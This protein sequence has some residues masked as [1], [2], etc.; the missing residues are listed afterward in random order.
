MARKHVI[1][2]HPLIW[3]LEGNV[4]LAARAR[5]VLD[6]PRSDLVLPVIALAE[7]T[8]LV[9]RRRVRISSVPSLLADI[10]ADP[11]IAIAPL[12]WDVFQHS[13]SLQAIPEMHDRFNVAT[14]LHLQSQGHTVTL[15]TKDET[16]TT[17]EF[18]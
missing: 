18:R 4:R 17:Y 5:A 15:V 3:Y 8:F 12:T 2:T 10:Q 6:D 9:E 16:I 14:A 11:R 1:D 7:A 13:L